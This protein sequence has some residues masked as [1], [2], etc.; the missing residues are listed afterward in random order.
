[1][2]LILPPSQEIVHVSQQCAEWNIVKSAD[3]ILTSYS[4]VTR[5]GTSRGALSRCDEDCL[6]KY[7]VLSYAF[8]ILESNQ[9]KTIRK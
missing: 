2:I 6:G 3:G 1:M 4:E 7:A 5:C 8:S 9:P